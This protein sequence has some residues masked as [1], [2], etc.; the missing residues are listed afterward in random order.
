[1]YLFIYFYIEIYLILLSTLDCH[2]FYA[3]KFS[4]KSPIMDATIK[5]RILH[6]VTAFMN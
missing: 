5:K 3:R 1:M 2:K 4:L 6:S